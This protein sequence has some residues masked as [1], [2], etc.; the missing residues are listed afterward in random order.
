[1][2]AT[3]MAAIACTFLGLLSTTTAFTIEKGAAYAIVLPEKPDAVDRFAANELAKHLELIFGLDLEIAK[4]SETGQRAG[5]F[6]VGIRPADDK[7]DLALEEARYRITS[8]ADKLYFDVF[9]LAYA[10]GMLGTDYDTVLGNWANYALTYYVIAKE[11]VDPRQ[12]FEHWQDEFCS[13]Y[14][15]AAC[16]VKA[17]FR[18]WRK[19]HAR[20]PIPAKQR[21]GGTLF[22]KAHAYYDP[23]YFKQ[24]DRL[25]RRAMA[26][27]DLAPAEKA[28]VHQLVLANRHNELWLK[29][30]AK[31]N[32]AFKGDAGTEP[33]KA[34]SLAATRELWNFRL[35]H[36]DEL[37]MYWPWVF[38]TETRKYGDSTRIKYWQDQGKLQ[39]RA[40]GQIEFENEHDRHSDMQ[41]E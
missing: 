33:D 12:S 17:Y 22:H 21:Y 23:A 34:A 31:G 7:A 18:H 38:T 35:A 24:A 15:A 41:D 5:L 26:R 40:T 1:M 19:V 14:G 9:Q 10:N 13:G 3:M 11:H 27:R 30:I 39:G 36:R 29:A 25:L 16:E 4:Q 20:N 32:R 6:F 8:D 37:D 2:R 28:R